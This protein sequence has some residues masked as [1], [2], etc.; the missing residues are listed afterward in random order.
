MRAFLSLRADRW[1]IRG[2]RG[3]SGFLGVPPD[4]VPRKKR[5]TYRFA[6]GLQ[7]RAHA[8]HALPHGEGTI[9]GSKR[10]RPVDL[11]NSILEQLPILASL[12]GSDVL[13]ALAFL[14][15]TATLVGFG[16]PG[17]LMPISFSSGALLGGWVGMAVVIAGAVL[18]SHAL[19]VVMRRWFAER[20]RKRWGERLAR[21]DRNME[22]RGFY[23]LLGLRLVG[24]PHVLVT[25][26]SSLSAIR[27]RS[28]VLATLLGFL[29]A[30]ALAAMAGSAV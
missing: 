29:P 16:V 2:M 23:Y 17:V 9:D 6:A 20:L 8:R 13:L 3:P 27:A 21:F 12:L 25:A 24:A 30:I 1:L 7:A 15:L 10:W 19:F 18:G 28:F 5:R 22:T 11:I 26:S 4:G 14:A